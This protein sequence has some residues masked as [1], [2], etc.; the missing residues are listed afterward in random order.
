LYLE[1]SPERLI[2]AAVKGRVGSGVDKPEGG[3]QLADLEGA[4]I[5]GSTASGV[6]NI[7]F[8]FFLKSCFL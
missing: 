6:H 8:V 1:A 3:A 4:E 5:V 2:A 7:I